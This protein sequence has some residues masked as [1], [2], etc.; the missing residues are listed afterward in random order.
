[1]I[2]YDVKRRL[3]EG[4]R[5]YAFVKKFFAITTKIFNQF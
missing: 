2:I 5:K 4:R 1:V 3:T